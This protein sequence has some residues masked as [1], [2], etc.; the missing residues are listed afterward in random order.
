[1]GTTKIKTMSREQLENELRE[2][3]KE[4]KDQAMRQWVCDELFHHIDRL[5]VEQGKLYQ[6]RCVFWKC[7]YI[8]FNYLRI[9]GQLGREP[10]NFDVDVKEF[11]KRLLED[12]KRAKEL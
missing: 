12:L 11:L 10:K 7:F 8:V 3:L 6:V 2:A 1:M 5:D 9:H 4:L